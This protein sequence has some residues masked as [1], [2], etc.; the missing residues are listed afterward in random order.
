MNYG[1][2]DIIFSSGQILDTELHQNKIYF[3]GISYLFDLS[4]K[5][6]GARGKNTND[7]PKPEEKLTGIQSIFDVMLY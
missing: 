3:P 7:V 1:M 4:L 6:G 2:I 5:G